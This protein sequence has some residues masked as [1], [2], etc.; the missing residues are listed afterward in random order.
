MI[1]LL[2]LSKPNVSTMKITIKTLQQKT[3]PL[4]ISE[5]ETV[6]SNLRVNF[7]ILGSEF[8]PPRAQVLAVKQRIE[9]EQQHGVA[10]QKLIFSGTRNLF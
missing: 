3:F 4:D 8:T 1:A 7:K 5:E 2:C 10:Q 6:C 9:S